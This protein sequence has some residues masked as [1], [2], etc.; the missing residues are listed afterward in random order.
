MASGH[1]AGQQA[2]A[3]SILTEVLQDG[4]SSRCDP[5]SGA[6]GA[7]QCPGPSS[8]SSVDGPSFLQPL[9]PGSLSLSL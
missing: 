2:S 5:R 3:V 4:T 7:L 8:L 6:R 1:C 9:V